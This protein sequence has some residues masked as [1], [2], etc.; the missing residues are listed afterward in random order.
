MRCTS[1]SVPAE[2]SHGF[3]ADCPAAVVAR[4]EPT[5]N[6]I[7]QMKRNQFGLDK[8]CSIFCYVC[9]IDI[10]KLRIDFKKIEISKLNPKL[11]VV[12]L[13]LR[14]LRDFQLT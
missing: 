8:I 9:L 14:K 7:T 5:H 13:I 12:E 4:L 11:F 10:D 1:G 6:K 3:G 2:A